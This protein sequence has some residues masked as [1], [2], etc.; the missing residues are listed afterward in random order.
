VLFVSINGGRTRHYFAFRTGFAVSRTVD[1]VF[2]R[3]TR[4]I[5]S[6]WN[7]GSGL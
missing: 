1:V 2:G 3:T 4:L 7:T 6:L 5:V